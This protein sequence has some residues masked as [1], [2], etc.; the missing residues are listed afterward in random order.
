M[1]GGKKV[2][3]EQVRIRNLRGFKDQTIPMDPYT[4]FVGPNGA[5]KSTI[6]CALNIFFRETEGSATNLTHLE[7]EDFFQK[8]TSEPIE[9]TVTFCNLTAAEAEAFEDYHRAG[10]LIVSAIAVFDATTGSAQ[11]KQYGNRVAMPDFAPFF[12]GLKAGARVGDLKDLFATLK[13][14]YDGLGGASTKDQMVAALQ[15]FEAEHQELCEVIASE[16]QFYGI[17]QA[18]KLRK[19]V[20]W[21][22]IPAVKDAAL[23][24]TEVRNTAFGRLVARTVRAQVNFSEE[25]NTIRQEAEQKYK[26]LVESKK[27][28]LDS[29]S[30]ALQTSLAQ[31]ANPNATARLDWHQ[32]PKTAVR[33]EEPVARLTT[34]DGLFEGNIA[35][36]GHGMQR[37][38][39]IA[40]LQG[41]SAIDDSDQ[42]TLIL[43]CEE[44]ELYQHPPQARHLSSVLQSLSETNAQIILTSHSPH[45]VDGRGFESVRMVRR[46]QTSSASQISYMTLDHLSALLSEASGKKAIPES[47][48]LAKLNQALQLNLS[49]MFFTDKLIIVEGL[50]DDAYITAWMRLTDRWEDFR[51]G[52]CHILPAGG[53]SEIARPFAIATALGIPVVAVFDCDGDKLS[54]ADENVAAGNRVRHEA[55]N[56]TILALAGVADDPFPQEPIWKERVVAW[57][58]EM[59]GWLKHS[60]GKEQWEALGNSASAAYQGAGNLQ[61]NTLHIAERLAKMFDEGLRPE[62][63]EQLCD[64]LVEFARSKHPA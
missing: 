23:E 52:G 37:S 46:C 2:R 21:V 30:S 29:V 3:I 14:K 28:A 47:G 6:L 60:M 25:L 50:E 43:G 17:G 7:T 36:F 11:V 10:K 56:R 26:Q 53:K 13:A 64:W 16:D 40:L 54:H 39:L 34:G 33:I 35:R 63:L 55:D 5:G 62:P 49:D 18:G 1:Q 42:P 57:P 8:D 61:K 51:K 22:Y 31:W 44:P 59:T 9:I 15:A 32:D 12:E 4:C 41:L 24:Q 19:F 38:Y 27:G 58:E 20:Q 48:T 45:F